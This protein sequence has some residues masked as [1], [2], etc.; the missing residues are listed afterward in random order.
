VQLVQ[1]INVET[2]GGSSCCEIEMQ[3][4]LKSL[5]TPL[6]T[7]PLGQGARKKQPKIVKYH[8][9]FWWKNAGKSAISAKKRSNWMLDLIIITEKM[10][11]WVQLVQ[12]V[13]DIL[14]FISLHLYKLMSYLGLNTLDYQIHLCYS[15][16]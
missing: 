8:E 1:N 13:W 9:V 4:W 11:I 10:L 5:A 16:L 14:C 3:L 6:P 7:P 2:T 15:Y 12:N